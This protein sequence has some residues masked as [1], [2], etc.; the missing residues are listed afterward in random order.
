MVVDFTASWCGPCQRMAPVFEGL[1][2]EFPQA[3]FCKV[4]VD[5]NPETAQ[6][7]GVRALPTFLLYKDE[8]QVAKLEG[9]DEA[10]LRAAIEQHVN[11]IDRFAGAGHR[12]GSTEAG[13]PST[14]LAPASQLVGLAVGQTPEEAARVAERQKRL[15]ALERR[16]LVGGGTSAGGVAPSPS[17]PSSPLPTPM[18]QTAAG[19]GAGPAMGLAPPR[20]PPRDTDTDE[21]TMLAA[22]LALSMSDD[23]SSVG[24][25]SP[26]PPPPTAPPPAALP[27]AAPPP[28]AAQRGVTDGMRP[29][30]SAGLTYEREIDLMVS[31]G[32]GNMEQNRMLLVAANGH[33]ERAI[34]MLLPAS[35]D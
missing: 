26:W 12:L 28:A 31:M 27:P 3:T 17:V 18:P 15:A 11:T 13:G 5:E 29:V 7:C 9:A 33:V 20:M 4:D 22:A 2:A 10:G 6:E 1:V 21:D 25:H 32:F 23:S 14:R 8:A 24:P 35:I 16:G 34:E 19:P 30:H